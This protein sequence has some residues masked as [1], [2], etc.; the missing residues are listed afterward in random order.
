MGLRVV[1]S[2]PVLVDSAEGGD[3]LDVTNDRPL[4]DFRRMSGRIDIMTDGREIPGPY[5]Q[6]ARENWLRELLEA[7]RWIRD[8]APEA[9]RDLELIATAEL[10]RLTTYCVILPF[11]SVTLLSA[12]QYS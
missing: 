12:P 7:Q 11:G 5:V 6:S 2:G 9:V 10:E 3:K 8:N 1:G 4:R